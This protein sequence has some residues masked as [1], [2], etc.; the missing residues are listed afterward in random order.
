MRAPLLEKPLG[1]R[2]LA[3]IPA[4]LFV[5]LA[6]TYSASI[7]N[8]LTGDSVWYAHDILAPSEQF[9]HPHHLMYNPLMRAMLAPFGPFMD[10]VDARLRYL[11]WVNVV[12]TSLAMTSLCVLMLRL[13]ADA[14]HACLFTLIPGLS[15]FFCATSSQ[16][17]VYGITV[18]CL[19]VA[20]LGLVR[21]EQ[22][23][24][25]RLLTALGYAAGMLFHQTAIFFGLAILVHEVA[26]H[27]VERAGL[28][29]KLILTLVLPVGAVG[30][31]YIAVGAGIGYRD[32]VSFWRWLT[33]HA[34]AGY[35]GKGTLSIFTLRTALGNLLNSL[36][37]RGPGMGWARPLLFLGAMA[38]GTVAAV[39]AWARG[40]LRHASLVAAALAWI[41][42]LACFSVWWDA[43]EAEYWGMVLVPVCLVLALITTP[44]TLGHT[45][46]ALRLMS[47]ACFIAGLLLLLGS[48]VVH[49]R[50]S[51]RP[52]LV[53][54][55]ARTLPRVARDGD[56]IWAANTGNST[57]YRIYMGS[58]PLTVLAI[59]VKPAREAA[60]QSTPATFTPALIEYLG[61]QVR[62]VE[63]GGGRCLMDRWALEGKVPTTRLM[64][65][66]DLEEF[67]QAM[68]DRFS[69]GPVGEGEEPFFYVL[70]AAGSLP[71]RSLGV[72]PSNGS[73]RV[74]SAAGLDPRKRDEVD[75]RHRRGALTKETAPCARPKS[76]L[77]HTPG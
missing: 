28:I 68:R 25:G 33:T 43:R 60:R 9:F 58:R 22:G 34:Q 62:A 40:G 75:A 13:G 29:R 2:T 19:C 47:T 20:S 66:I 54:E 57:L 1:G 31:I 45:P 16:I 12:I 11:Q 35:W 44:A 24:R 65:D 21:T 14:P 74:A 63:S 39:T 71:S 23:G 70:H 5:A 77:G 32:P 59:D 76:L 18:L 69:A 8:H 15:A 56:L 61:A 37:A 7:T 42:A 72:R 38:L 52:N 50:L 30:L 49:H 53:W 41:A 10:G 17:E 55:A 67:T 46:V 64:K 26:R 51:L 27:R 36:V 73:G 48:V 3:V 6:L 4:A